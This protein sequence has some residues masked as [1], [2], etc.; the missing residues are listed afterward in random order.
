MIPMEGEIA[1]LLP[2]PPVQAKNKLKQEQVKRA[3]ERKFS[4]LWRRGPCAN[5]RQLA[6]GPVSYF[7]ATTV[8]VSVSVAKCH[9]GI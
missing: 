7:T 6:H 9:L 3:P 4:A 8:T 2:V 1:S 5:R